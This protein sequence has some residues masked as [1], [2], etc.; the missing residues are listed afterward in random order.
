MMIYSVNATSLEGKCGSIDSAMCAGIAGTVL[1][2]TN[3]YFIAELQKMAS[4]K[5]DSDS[6]LFD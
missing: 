4:R 2:S 5:N 6:Y 3:N 1:I